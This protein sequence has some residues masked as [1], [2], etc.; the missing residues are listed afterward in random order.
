MNALLLPSLPSPSLPKCLWPLFGAASSLPACRYLYRSPAILHS[1]VSRPV[2]AP[3]RTGWSTAL[4]GRK[5][6]ICRFGSA[7]L[8]GRRAV[9]CAA[10]GTGLTICSMWRKP[11][12]LCDNMQYMSAGALR[13][14]R[15]HLHSLP[16]SPR[17][18]PASLPRM[19][20][21]L[22][23]ALHLRPAGLRCN[24]ARASLLAG[25]ISL[26]RVN[27]ASRLRL[28]LHAA[29]RTYAPLP[30][31]GCGSEDV[32]G[33]RFARLKHR[34]PRHQLS[35]FSGPET[36]C[37]L[38]PSRG[39]RLGGVAALPTYLPVC[40]AL[41]LSTKILFYRSRLNDATTRLLQRV[42]C[43]HATKALRRRAHHQPANGGGMPPL[44]GTNCLRLQ[45]AIA[46]R[47]VWRECYCSATGSLLRHRHSYAATNAA[48]AARQRSF[49]G[50][51]RRFMPVFRTPWT[52]RRTRCGCAL[53]GLY[54][55]WYCFFS[56]FERTTW[57]GSGLEWFANL[58]TSLLVRREGGRTNTASYARLFRGCIC[59][60]CAGCY[61]QM[62]HT[63]GCATCAAGA[64]LGGKAF[65]GW[66][67]RDGKSGGGRRRVW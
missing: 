29:A 12:C 26:L 64:T 13:A 4:N 28:P 67:N 41:R 50:P 47:A 48:D 53:C 24:N 2:C 8:S 42:F 23:A 44:H 39:A 9:I 25:G 32:P 45:N 34:R 10:G 20:N 31:A 1:P 21:R 15:Q 30:H 55:G 35:R 19:V 56:I 60:A 18:L 14:Y 49:T 52:E 6:W 22:R 46:E 7:V 33:A 27:R 5:R 11:V 62:G 51:P 16:Y 40:T 54:Q 63:A 66:R 36:A 38:P 43:L 57:E 61:H 37:L 3:G 65:L 17:L 58:R 59:K